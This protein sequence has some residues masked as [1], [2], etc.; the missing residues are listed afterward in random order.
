MLY[1]LLKEFYSKLEKLL[2]Y[3]LADAVLEKNYD[4]KITT[5]L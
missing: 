3:H 5:K 4:L 2:I 1:Q